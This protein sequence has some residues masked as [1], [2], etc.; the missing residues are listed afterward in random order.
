M[1]EIN[2]GSC[3]EIAMLVAG[4]WIL[5]ARVATPG[6]SFYVAS[7]ASAKSVRVAQILFAVSVPLIGL[8]HLVYAKDTAN[9]VPAWL[10]DRMDWACLTGVAHIAA[11]VA[12]LLVVLPRLAAALEALMMGIFTVFVW[13]PAIV[14]APTQRF[15][16]TAFLISTALTAA[17]WIV[18]ESY[19]EVPWF[20]FSRSRNLAAQ[21]A[22][23]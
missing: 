7:L 2:W 1:H 4:G 19:R 6:D 8:E 16:W 11:G 18:A 14:A 12:I 9:Y 10:P 21:P 15:G 3:G 13:I 17:A 5:Y 20:S 22:S 23:R